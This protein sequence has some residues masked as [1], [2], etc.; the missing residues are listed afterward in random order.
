MCFH[1]VV[2]NVLAAKTFG[3]IREGSMWRQTITTKIETSRH[4]V[5]SY[6][7]SVWMKISTSG[8]LICL[9]HLQLSINFC[10]FQN[11]QQLESQ[12]SITSPIF[13]ANFRFSVPQANNTCFPTKIFQSWGKVY[14]ETAWG[15]NAKYKNFS[16]LHFRKSAQKKS[17]DFSMSKEYFLDSRFP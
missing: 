4:T 14:D 5:C 10:D 6:R 11:L 3:W 13:G 17:L 15:E 16:H 7:Y 12:G 2:Y 1:T 8:H 9:S